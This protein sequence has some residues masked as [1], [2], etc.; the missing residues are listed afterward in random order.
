MKIS[1]FKRTTLGLLILI[2]LFAIGTLYAQQAVTG[3][4]HGHVTDPDGG[5]IPNALVT[6]TVAGKTIST[7]TEGDGSYSLSP[8]PAGTYTINASVQGFT[9]L[10]KNGVV[11]AAGQILALGFKLDIQVQAQQVEVTAEAGNTLDTNPDNS[12]SAIV[13]KG[14]DLDALSDDPD[15]LQNEL[16]AL[17]GP[18][19]GPNGGQI[20]VDGF[21]AGQLPPK[22]AIREIRINQ[23]PFSAEY[24]QL[25]YGRIE[26]FT[27]PG[28]DKLHG[29]FLANINQQVLNTSN[30]FAP[31]QPPY[32]TL[33]WTGN[34]SGPIS[35]KASYFLSGSRRNIQANSLINTET[36][37]CMPAAGMTTGCP[38]VP[39]N[40]AYTDAFGNPQ[41]RTEISQRLD[42][43]VTPNNTLSVRYQFEEGTQLNSSVGGNNLPLQ[44]VNTLSLEHTLQVSDTQTLGHNQNIVN[45]VHFQYLRDRNTNAPVST[46]P[47]IS[48]SGGENTGGSNGGYSHDAQDR[49]EFQDYTSIAL[50]KNFIRFG[51]RLRITRDA[52][53]SNGGFNSSYT[54]APATYFQANPSAT[55]ANCPTPSSTGCRSVPGIDIY[56]ITLYNL[57]NGLAYNACPNYTTTDGYTGCGGPSQA[58]ITNGNP[59]IIATLNDVG[60]YAETDWKARPN[61]T[62]SYGLRWESQSDINDKSDWAPRVAVAWGLDGKG[63]TPPKTLLRAG[64]GVF[65]NRFQL[66]SVETARRQAIGNTLAN[67]TKTTTYTNPTS[68]SLNCYSGPCT[69][70]GSAVNTEPTYY[71]I[72]PNLH[73]ATT[74]QGAITLERQ[75]GKIGT[76]TLNYLHSRGL[77]QY[78]TLQL[79]YSDQNPTATYYN[80]QLSSEGIYKQNQLL[81]NF[82]LRAGKNVSITT[83]YSLSYAKATPGSP[84]NSF[85]LNQDYGR[86]SFDVRSRLYVIGN[87][88]LPYRI[89]LSPFLVYQSGNPYNITAGSDINQDGNF[90]DRPEYAP[91]GTSCY[92]NDNAAAEAIVTSFGCFAI[93]ATGSTYTPIPINFGTGPNLFTANLRISKTFGFGP[94][95]GGASTAQNGGGRGGGPG[96]GPGGMGG[97]GGGGPGGGGGGGDRGGGGGYGGG[98][99]GGGGGGGGGGGRG[100]GG[101]GGRGGNRVADRKYSIG[102]SAAVQNLFNEVNLAAPNGTLISP[103]FGQSTQ[104]AG[105]IYTGGSTDV[106]T[107]RAQMTFSF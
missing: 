85:N 50:S 16:E 65:Y 47:G 37:G 46:L 12:A 93:P 7:T 89:T 22:N 23:N 33:Q 106:R 17:A 60:L 78:D 44:G 67:G 56:A 84:S 88:T 49:Y 42:Y 31:N 27:K 39:I 3:S 53:Y 61:V 15:E 52:N 69:P 4:I 77:H 13:L 70:M 72:Q 102:F 59:A 24:D 99:F 41:R 25:G 35:S 28:T 34:V 80:N 101:G 11:L 86:S 105:G 81:A 5:V 103:T 75:V 9:P 95:I 48:V 36:A 104:L 6:T 19:A 18:A 96:G 74:V 2:G 45:E 20:Y 32:D 100:G 55:A 68:F 1:I 71:Y 63:K 64:F 62:V 43:L 54:F 91:T 14:K 30:P 76:F 66:G 21:T 38:T 10:T 94:K 8:L 90:N 58:S 83:F 40:D 98:G 92:T 79:G 107:I 51:G 82:N 87:V 29:Q 57:N 97:P 26:I 73:A